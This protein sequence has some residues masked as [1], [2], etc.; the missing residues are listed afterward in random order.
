MYKSHTH[1]HTHTHRDRET[2]RQTDRQTDTHTHT[3]PIF[4]DPNIHLVYS[5]C[6]HND[7]SNAKKTTCMK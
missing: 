4:S 1:T 3:Q 5:Y 7:Y 6:I 2:D